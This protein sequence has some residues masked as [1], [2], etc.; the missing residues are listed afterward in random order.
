[1]TNRFLFL[2]CLLAIFSGCDETKFISATRSTTISDSIQARVLE[3]MPNE[4]AG[5]RL[6]S[7]ATNEVIAEFEERISDFD[8]DSLIFSVSDYAGDP[9]IE[10]QQNQLLVLDLDRNELLP[11]FTVPDVDLE[12]YSSNSIEYVMRFDDS[13]SRIIADRFLEDKGVIVQFRSFI[14]GKPVTFQVK[15]TMY[16]KVTGEIL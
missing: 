14:T 7:T 11:P 10:L 1:M 2:V 5:E 13:E 4:I 15:A 3:A 12:N 16:M 8:V 6:L 9:G